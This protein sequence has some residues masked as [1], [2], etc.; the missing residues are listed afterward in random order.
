MKTIAESGTELGKPQTPFGCFCKAAAAH[1]R[2]GIGFCL[3][4]PCLTDCLP[5]NVCWVMKFLA[6]VSKISEIFA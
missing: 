5:T 2:L 6:E 3:T 1:S 4:Y